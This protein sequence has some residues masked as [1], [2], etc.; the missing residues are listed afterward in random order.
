MPASDRPTKLAR[1][2]VQV[3]TGDGKG[4][5][6]AAIGLAVRAAGAGLRT[7]FAQFIKGRRHSE[8]AALERFADL[9]AVRQFG[10][11]RFIGVTP[12]PE[13]VAAARRGLAE[14][15]EA[16]ASGRYDLVVLDEGNTA[17]DCGLLTAADLV[18]LSEAKP[19]AV[20]LI[21]TGR[22]APAQVC[23]RADLVTEMAPVKHYF[24]KG[25]TARRGIEM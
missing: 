15:A 12:T 8:H 4:K 24:D 5:T 6:T 22:T 18:A 19:E 16:L 21:I 17:V 23:E 7:F 20:E 11:G 3:Y 10:R 9:I 2:Y 14:A 13:D 25:V 1:G